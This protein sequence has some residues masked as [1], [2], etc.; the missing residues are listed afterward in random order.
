ML[1]AIGVYLSRSIAAQSM[2]HASLGT[3]SYPAAECGS[4]YTWLTFRVARHP[5]SR[6]DHSL[7][8][9]LTYYL[10]AYSHHRHASPTGPRSKVY[11]MTNGCICPCFLE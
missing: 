7:S 5:T 9:Y 4:K 10:R 1:D 3:P 6:P 11:F 8:M 2:F